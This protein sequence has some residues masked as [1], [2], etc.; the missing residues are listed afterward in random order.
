MQNG[1]KINKPIL[2]QFYYYLIK[3]SG[4]GLLYGLSLWGKTASAP[5]I[6]ITSLWHGDPEF[7]KEILK[8]GFRNKQKLNP[9]DK[10]SHI[11]QQS[12]NHFNISKDYK[13]NNHADNNDQ[14]LYHMN[15]FTWLVD[16]AA[17]GKSDKIAKYAQNLCKNWLEANSDFTAIKYNSIAWQTDITAK[18]VFSWLQHWQ[19][20]FDRGELNFRHD[21]LKS[22]ARQIRHLR[23]MAAYQSLSDGNISAVKGWICACLILKSEETG[24]IAATKALEWVLAEQIFADGGH[25][26]RIPEKQLSI[27]QDLIDI[28]LVFRQA[29]IE[30]PDFLQITIDKMSPMLRFYRHPDK[31]LAV[32]NGGNIKNKD[33]I[34]SILNY[35]D[36]RGIAPKHAP[37][38]G[39]EKLLA[40]NLCAFIDVGN[41]SPLIKYDDI[42]AGALAIEVSL[43]ENRIFVN[44]G[45]SIAG[46]KQWRQSERS[47]AAHSTLCLA[48]LNSTDLSKNSKRHAYV[49]STYSTKNGNQWVDASHDGYMA[50]MG[51]IH[52]RRL[53]MAKDGNDLRGEDIIEG[54]VGIDYSISFHLHPKIKVSILHNKQSALLKLANG[55]AWRLRISGAA[56]TLMDSIYFGDNGKFKR[57]Q[58]IILSGITATNKT[59]IKWALRHDNI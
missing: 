31:S 56:I 2:G 22:I 37:H 26:S 5:K 41:P 44:C 52:T 6:N 29:K 12:S 54:K 30:T 16:L 18:R 51:I 24:L 35:A 34:D 10:S 11:K 48:N 47:T 23:N 13:N 20:F 25:I 58:Q 43:G 32:F 21:M 50:N 39:Y 36:A 42:F 28:R 14:W 55:E 59:K 27:L 19:V 17:I 4:Q 38:S 40:G 46:N 49:T 57:S 3:L 1:L 33:I 53:F 9:Q 8:Y 15:S 45:K 7:G